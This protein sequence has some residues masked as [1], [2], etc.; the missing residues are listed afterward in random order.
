MQKIVLA[1]IP[2]E[3]LELKEEEKL[4]SFGLEDDKFVSYDG[5][6][7]LSLMIEK[8]GNSVKVNGGISFEVK[9]ICVR[10]LEPFSQKISP[11]I[12]IIYE[13]EP[14]GAMNKEAALTGKESDTSYYRKNGVIEL[15]DAIREFV[16]LSLP[17]KPVCVPD[18]SGLCPSCGKNLNQ[19]SCSCRRHKI[20]PRFS[21]LKD[22]KERKK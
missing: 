9:L 17:I 3:G 13:P 11:A 12:D 15:E 19:G 22:F 16:L 8:I 1:D 10:C 4:C 5:P 20:D 6:M 21:K 7:R 18:C 14:S 2:S